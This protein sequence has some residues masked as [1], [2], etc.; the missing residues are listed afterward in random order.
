MVELDL[1]ALNL[2]P[3]IESD[4]GMAV[5][6]SPAK[7]VVLDAQTVQYLRAS[8]SKSICHRIT[9]S[10]ILTTYKTFQTLVELFAGN[11]T[12]D[13]KALHDRMCRLKFRPGYDDER[14]IGDFQKLLEDY[15]DI[16][17]IYLFNSHHQLQCTYCWPPT[18]N[19]Q[20]YLSKMIDSTRTCYSRN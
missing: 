19:K 20:K 9:N 11:R 12:Q 14:F 6:V 7:R 13:Y 1:R 3:F 10:N 8:I 15:D 5:N 16:G 2:L 17:T 4:C 18:I